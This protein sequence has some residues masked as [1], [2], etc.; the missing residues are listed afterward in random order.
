MTAWTAVVVPLMIV[1]KCAVDFIG[2]EY[3]SQHQP[4]TDNDF[5]YASIFVS[6]FASIVDTVNFW[7]KK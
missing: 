5:L 2:M 7:R 1:A 3:G 6:S 4:L